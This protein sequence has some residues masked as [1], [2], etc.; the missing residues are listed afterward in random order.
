VHTLKQENI[1]AVIV[2]GEAAIKAKCH[3]NTSEED[4][5]YGYPSSRVAYKAD[6]VTF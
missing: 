2:G 1:I 3:P 6:H 4:Y 5:R